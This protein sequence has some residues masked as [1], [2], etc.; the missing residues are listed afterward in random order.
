MQEE[1]VDC[2][3]ERCLC[4]LLGEFR[5]FLF[6]LIRGCCWMTYEKGGRSQN[7]D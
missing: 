2:V 5:V 3:D 6:F 4:C 1:V 7:S